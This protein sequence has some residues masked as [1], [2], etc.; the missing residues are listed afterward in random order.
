MTEKTKP[1][2]AL[3][4]LSGELKLDPRE[5]RKR[6]R[7]AKQ[8]AKAFPLL[9]AHIAGGAWEW[10]EGSPQLTEAK[11]ALNTPLPEKKPSA[12]E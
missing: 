1:M 9:A 5:G 11:K 4:T 2:I 3:K 6:L 7:Y 12:N 8:D 10:P